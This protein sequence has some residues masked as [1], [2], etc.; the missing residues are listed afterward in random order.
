[1]PERKYLGNL[2][3][4]VSFAWLGSCSGLYLHFN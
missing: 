1:M 2:Q 3:L 4:F